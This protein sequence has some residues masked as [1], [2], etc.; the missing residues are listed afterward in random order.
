MQVQ[1]S[2][3][4]DTTEAE[5]R[6]I[7]ELKKALSEARQEKVE[8]VRRVDVDVITI[9]NLQDDLAQR[10]K[11][12]EKRQREIDELRRRSR[13]EKTRNLDLEE[14]MKHLLDLQREEEQF[15]VAEFGPRLATYVTRSEFVA[16]QEIIKSF[17]HI[18]PQWESDAQRV[19]NGISHAERLVADAK[20]VAGS[21]PLGAEQMLDE[22][23]STCADLEAAL[24]LRRQL[25]P[26]PPTDL[27]VSVDNQGI[28]LSWTPS[29]SR[30][31]RYVIVRKE[32]SKPV[33]SHDGER[34]AVAAATHWRDDSPPAARPVWYAVY[35][36]RE[37]TM[38]TS[39]VHSKRAV[40]FIP[41]V[42]EPRR[43]V[44]DKCITLS[45]RVPAHAS[46][47]LVVRRE[48]TAPRGSDDGKRYELGRTER[49]E[50][51]DV[52]NGTPYFYRVYCEYLDA[53]YVTHH[54]EGLVLDAIPAPPP[55]EV[56]ALTARGSQGLL[57]HTVNLIVASPAQGD[58]RVYRSDEAPHIPVSTTVPVQALRTVFGRT[59]RPVSEMRDTLFAATCAFYTP[60]ILFH[61]TAFL[62]QPCEYSY[63]PPLINV[64]AETTEQ[65]IRVRWK[66]TYG[67]NDAEVYCTLRGA[68]A[69][70]PHVRYVPRVEST[71]ADPCVEFPAMSRGAYDISVRARYL[72]GDHPVFS[73][74]EY[75]TAHLSGP[76]V[77]RY[78]A[79]AQ[80]RVFG[81][82]QYQIVLSASE[83]LPHDPPPCIVVRSEER[84]PAHPG[85]GEPVPISAAQRREDGT[86]ILPLDGFIPRP[87][88]TL[89]VFPA[90]G[91]P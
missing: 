22:A 39:A 63:G 55:R 91:Q 70:K 82:K 12:E 24:E 83:P 42:S 25:P 48:G 2:R 4:A 72:L 13:E 29:P 49:F 38:S 26:A 17:A 3:R 46:A 20:R 62:G 71:D 41:D 36:E 33:S 60:V 10:K 66:W 79:R 8:A 90:A 64:R 44:T 21:D 69:T 28:S 7:D 40:L 65:T 89:A 23:L 61:D 27:Q 53:A 9:R 56:P 47:I 34:I 87:T 35:A 30:N 16:A 5:Q 45:W 51:R 15:R 52:Q 85:D 1:P 18:P 77:I 50:D 78:A 6:V 76:L 84:V 75:M 59:G 57:N 31:V 37:E 88:T 58:L 54:S 14:Q 68:S 80:N 43:N 32:G 81:G 74:P 86:W 11:Q 67:C 73:D 19:A